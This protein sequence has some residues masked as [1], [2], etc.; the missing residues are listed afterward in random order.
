MYTIRRLT[1]L[2]L[3]ALLTSCGVRG[4]LYLPEDQNHQGNQK[5]QG[6]QNEQ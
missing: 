6:N 3:L 4:A 5:H 2:V 1:L